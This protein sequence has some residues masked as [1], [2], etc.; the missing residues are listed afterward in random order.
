[1]DMNTEWRQIFYSVLFTA[2]HLFSWWQYVTWN[3]LETRRATFSCSVTVFIS[4]YYIILVVCRA[5]DASCCSVGG[6]IL[7]LVVSLDVGCLADAQSCPHTFT[8]RKCW[9]WT[10]QG[11]RSL[12]RWYEFSFPPSIFIRELSWRPLGYWLLLFFNDLV[13]LSYFLSALWVAEFFF[14]FFCF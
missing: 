1:M 11:Y 3:R 7:Q 8:A 14:F 13:V 4:V 12:Q 5:H 9:R 10:T 2:L 6:E